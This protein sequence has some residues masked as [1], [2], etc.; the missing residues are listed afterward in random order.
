M[1]KT[2]QFCET[3]AT[4]IL[5]VNKMRDVSSLLSFFIQVHTLTVLIAVQVR[6]PAESTKWT[7]NYASKFYSATA[8]ILVITTK[9]INCSICDY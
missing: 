2:I 1:N 7:L 6:L 9:L 4:R 3:V 5:N 8:D